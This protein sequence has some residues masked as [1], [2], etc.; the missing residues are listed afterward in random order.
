MARTKQ[1]PRKNR[2]PKDASSANPLK[3]KADTIE[4]AETRQD[5]LDSR[6]NAVGRKRNKTDGNE[7]S[8]PLLIDDIP[9][10]LRKLVKLEMDRGP[11]SLIDALARCSEPYKANCKQF[12][13]LHAQYTSGVSGQ[14]A[15]EVDSASDYSEGD[16]DIDSD[17][18]SVDLA[19]LGNSGEAELGDRLRRGSHHEHNLRER[20]PKAALEANVE[21][22][23]KNKDEIQEQDFLD[24]E[25]AEIEPVQLRASVQQLAARESITNIQSLKLHFKHGMPHRKAAVKIHEMWQSKLQ[26]ALESVDED[27]MSV[28]AVG[29]HTPTPE[30]EAKPPGI[31]V[32]LDPT[33]E[34]MRKY[35]KKKAKRRDVKLTDI[36]PVP[37]RRLVQTE[38]STLHCSVMDAL[39]L[40]AMNGRP[41]RKPAMFLHEKWSAGVALRQAQ[42]AGPNVEQP[43]V[44]GHLYLDDEMSVG[45]VSPAVE[46]SDGAQV[47]QQGSSPDEGQVSEG[48]AGV[49]DGAR[50]E[51]VATVGDMVRVGD[52]DEQDQ[53]LQAKYF[54]LTD[55]DAY[56]LCLSCGDAG[57]EE[58][59]CPANACAH[60]GRTGA[61]F[62]AAC[63]TYRKCGKCRQRGHD[64]AHCTRRAVQGGGQD[65]PCDVCAHTGHV[66]EECADLWR[67]IGTVDAQRQVT[68]IAAPGMRKACYNC[69]S[70][71]HWGDNCDTLPGYILKKTGD[72]GT[73][74][75]QHAGKYLLDDQEIEEQPAYGR[76]AP[77]AYYPQSYQL[78]ALDY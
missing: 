66:E 60:C 63:P 42:E 61:H 49:Q 8:R 62:A 16:M 32:P 34:E 59:S 37:L 23:T 41:Y 45:E 56:C 3:R 71:K 65:D 13:K 78:A 55:P 14:P 53:R 33:S 70:N 54:M 67:T 39:S 29:E 20:R 40:C 58:S 74:S 68:R 69:G 21:P 44:A 31:H 35:I 17:S 77:A 11:G 28:A 27:A 36:Q 30:P 10:G 76:P 75:A 46:T 7:F 38:V 12:K 2:Q 51:D 25:L 72:R 50:I 18:D 22:T 47:H 26:Q 5:V 9:K 48:S 24:I 43:A 15:E 57:H 64:A 4:E 73:W 52:L 19:S 1:I 6:T